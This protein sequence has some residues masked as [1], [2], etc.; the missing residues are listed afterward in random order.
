MSQKKED[1]FL[2]ELEML[3]SGESSFPFTIY[4]Y[5]TVNKRFN[6]QLHANS[7][8]D[9]ERRE[10]IEFFLDKGAK[11]AVKKS[12]KK[13]F[14]KNT[15]LNEEE[16]E[17]LKE[18]VHILEAKLEE[19]RQAQKEEEKAIEAGQAPKKKDFNI[20]QNLTKSIRSNNFSPLID[21]MKEE[22]LLFDVRIA[23]S[24]TMAIKFVDLLLGPDN[25]TNR[26]VALS[27]FLAKN[28]KIDDPEVL[29]E[30]ICAAYLHKIGYSQL[31]SHYCRKAHIEYTDYENKQLKNHP[32]L[33]QHLIRKSGAQLSERT[34]RLILEHKELAHGGGY[35]RQKTESQLD[36]LSLTL[37]L[38]SHVIEYSRGAVTGTATPNILAI[39][40][41]IKNKTPSPGLQLDFGDNI[42]SNL[43]NLIDITEEVKAA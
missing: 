10:R 2:I 27:Y 42:I 21:K 18:E 41:K 16:V 28:N 13:T 36:P 23:N 11:L 3:P 35:P 7:P 5:N 29:S 9:Q 12:Q 40:N 30:L 33:A 25:H 20:R 26:I 4:L 38:S 37:G 22:V 31:D 39:V 8:L 19:R 43:L 6:P 15:G 24:V 1:Y 17:G 34:I 14:L 32:G